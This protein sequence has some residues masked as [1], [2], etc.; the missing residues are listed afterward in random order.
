M[1]GRAGGEKAGAAAPAF[2][3]EVAEV[4][5]LRISASTRSGVIG[6]RVRRAPVAS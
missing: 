6:S 1:A 2:S 4:Q 3:V 5:T